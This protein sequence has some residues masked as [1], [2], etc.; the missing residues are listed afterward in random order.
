MGLPAIRGD[1][2]IDTSK[3]GNAV[4]VR[5][6]AMWLICGI[7]ASAKKGYPASGSKVVSIR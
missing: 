5:D 6:N 7:L 4:V 1:C 3:G 2:T